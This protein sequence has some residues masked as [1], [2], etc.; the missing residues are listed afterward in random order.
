MTWQASGMGQRVYGLSNRFRNLVCLFVSIRLCWKFFA[1]VPLI[2]QRCTFVYA[3][4]NHSNAFFVISFDWCV[5]LAS[6]SRS[7]Y[8][9]IRISFTWP[10]AGYYNTY[11]ILQVI[12]LDGCILFRVHRLLWLWVYRRSFTLLSGLCFGVLF[13][14][15][16][17]L[18]QAFNVFLSVRSLKVESFMHFCYNVLQNSRFLG[19]TDVCFFSAH[20]KGHWFYFRD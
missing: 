5:R 1:P 4:S 13:R 8:L 12:L 7:F 18:R 6:C 11:C 19:K 14:V 3:W 15:W 17:C 10:I 16:V 2:G 9:G 20:L